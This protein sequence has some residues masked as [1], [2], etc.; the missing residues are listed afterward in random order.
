[1]S[2]KRILLN[3]TLIR[4]FSINSSVRQETKT[5]D[6]RFQ[7][8]SKERTLN[9][10]QIIGRVGHNPRITGQTNRNDEADKSESQQKESQSNENKEPIEKAKR[11][12]IVLFSMATNEYQ[13]MDDKAEPKYRTDWHRITLISRRLQEYALRNVHQGDRLHVTGRLHYDLVKNKSGEPR[14]VT[15]IVADDLILLDKFESTEN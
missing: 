11:K 12:S 2:L 7:N 10:I 13:G 3:N 14:L 5:A 15:N 1:M 4:S 8:I 6:E 9:L